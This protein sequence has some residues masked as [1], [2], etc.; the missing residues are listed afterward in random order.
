MHPCIE[1]LKAFKKARVECRLV[2]KQAKKKSWR[3]FI[4]KIHSR[5]PTKTV[6]NMVHKIKGKSHLSKD[7]SPIIYTK[8]TVYFLAESFSKLSEALARIGYIER[9][10]ETR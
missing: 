8:E 4:T 5:I 9:S 10:Y 2:V 7:N 3:S 6:W 1:N